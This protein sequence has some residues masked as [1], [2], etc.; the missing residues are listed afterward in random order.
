MSGVVLLI[1]SDCDT[2]EILTALLTWE[3]YRVLESDNPGDGLRM[4]HE[5]QPGIIVAE[6]LFPPGQGGRCVA[7]ELR[8]NPRTASIP[9]IIFTSNRSRECRG[10]IDTAGALYLAKPAS[11]RSV[12]EAIERIVPALSL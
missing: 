10:R 6:Y 5:E 11:P 3:G 4:A 1:D 12:L 8:L 9:V 2:R 7:E